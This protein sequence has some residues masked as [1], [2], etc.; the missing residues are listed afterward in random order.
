MRIVTEMNDE[1]VDYISTLF[2][3]RDSYDR[4]ST[5]AKGKV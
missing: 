4:A 3:M 2:P 5:K 1:Y